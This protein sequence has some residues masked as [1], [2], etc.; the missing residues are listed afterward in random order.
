M[1]RLVLAALTIAALSPAFGAAAQRHADKGCF[2]ITDVGDRTVAGP[3]TLYF[4]VK[5]AAHMHA[6]AYYR[7]ETTGRCLAGVSSPSQHAGF[8][9]GSFEVAPRKSMEVCKTADLMIKGA[10][11]N[12]QVASMTQVTPTEIAALPR[13]LRP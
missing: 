4:K 13:G 2:L 11:P 1:K 9:V 8:Q 6:I 12:C 5:D 7:V 3:H 10:G